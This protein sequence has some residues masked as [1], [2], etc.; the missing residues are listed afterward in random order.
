[1]HQREGPGRGELCRVCNVVCIYSGHVG[2]ACMPI[3]RDLAGAW[4]RC[5]ATTERAVH[6]GLTSRNSRVRGLGDWLVATDA[7]ISNIAKMPMHAQR[8]LSA[9][10]VALDVY[11]F[12]FSLR[13]DTHWDASRRLVNW[14]AQD[15]GA[16]H[17]CGWLD[18]LCRFLKDCGM[19]GVRA[20][21]K[22]WD[23]ARIGKDGSRRVPDVVCTHPRTGVEYVLD[24]RI[25]WNTMS[26][27]PTGYT[28]YSHTGWGAEHGESEKR[29]SWKASIKRADELSAGGVEFV[30][31]SIE[32]GGVW[33][34]AARKFF[35]EC[36]A[37]A[38]DDRDVDLY[39]WSST[40]FSRAWFDSLSVLV[41]RGRAKV[42]AAAAASDWPKRI[43]DMQ[44]IDV[45]DLD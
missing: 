42:S 2:A 3:A 32:A 18:A 23:P 1:M 17:D 45:E 7:C 27:G 25:Y 5:R 10:V 38:D 37:L 4:R 8:E 21:L 22:Y 31:F 29:A 30:P 44:H 19:E 28:A 9:S 43:R 36:V 34:P 40:R 41:A 13:S 16:Q 33:G 11:A 39:H 24:A 15:H 35:R 14:R 20:E 12:E 6:L 26:E